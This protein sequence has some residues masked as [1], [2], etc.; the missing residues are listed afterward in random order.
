[1]LPTLGAMPACSDL[2]LIEERLHRSGGLFY[3]HQ[4]VGPILLPGIA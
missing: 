1:M 3:R 4:R 2:S